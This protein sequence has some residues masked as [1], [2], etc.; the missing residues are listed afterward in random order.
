[1]VA[2]P[3]QM[4]ISERSAADDLVFGEEP[5]FHGPATLHRD[6][7]VIFEYAMGFGQYRMLY[8][9]DAVNEHPRVGGATERYAPST[10]AP[11][12]QASEVVYL[13]DENGAPFRVPEFSK[14]L[15]DYREAKAMYLIGLLN[16]DQP[17]VYVFNPNSVDPTPALRDLTRFEK[18]ALERL[19]QGK[20]LVLATRG[21]KLMML[22]AIRARKECV[23]CHEQP[24]GGL[25]GAFS[26]E[27]DEQS[28][29]IFKR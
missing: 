18:K 8:M 10:E 3:S 6:G 14:G 19:L 16:H 9:R 22:G 12:T 23:K 1:M 4:P 29:K 20:E 15:R 2:N 28:A 17:I 11:A 21:D 24:L 7:V 5:A 25:L 27:I 26:Y 13:S